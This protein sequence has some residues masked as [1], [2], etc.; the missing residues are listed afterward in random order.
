[1][2]KKLAVL[3]A[4]ASTVGVSSGVY[5]QATI[6]APIAPKPAAGSTPVLFPSEQG[7]FKALEVATQIVESSILQNGC[8]N[9]K[10]GFSVKTNGNGNGTAVLANIPLTISLVEASDIG[11]SYSV[12]GPNGGVAGLRLLDP[13]NNF[14][15]TGVNALGSY[16][17]G[18][19]MQEVTT[20]F[21][22]DSTVVPDALD[23]FRGTVIKDYWRLT[24][25]QPIPVGVGFT[26][27]GVLVNTVINYGYQ[28][29]Q[30][31]RMI[32][33]KYWQQSQFWR[34]NGVRPGTYWKKV[35]VAPVDEACTIEVILQGRLGQATQD[36]ITGFNETGFINVIGDPNSLPIGAFNNKL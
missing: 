28:Q 8:G 31:N 22:G 6:P 13:V 16:N 4:L 7:A 25:L 29:I 3:V 34:Q 19:E 15:V 12:I 33:A 5:A 26:N 21:S 36:N 1:M 10:Y 9:A 20:S 32:A 17:I 24:A 14:S 11:R 23:S 35:R 18:S 30:K 27:Q 2:K